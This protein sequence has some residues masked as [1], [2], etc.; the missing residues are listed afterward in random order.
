SPLADPPDFSARLTLPEPIGLVGDVM[1]AL[2]R[3]LIQLC[4]RL[5]DEQKGARVLLLTLR[6]VDRASCGIELH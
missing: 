3:L 4:A 2:E 1:A 6:R 5:N